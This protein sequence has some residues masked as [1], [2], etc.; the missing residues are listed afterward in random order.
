MHAYYLFFQPYDKKFYYCH[1]NS[2][3]T[4]RIIEHY[5]IPILRESQRVN[6]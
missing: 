3:Q 5:I 1:Q 4:E 2:K 6:G